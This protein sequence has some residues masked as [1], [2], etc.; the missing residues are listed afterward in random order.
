MGCAK[1]LWKQGEYMN[2][3]RKKTRN[4]WNRT[5]QWRKIS[6]LW[7]VKWKGYEQSRWLQRGE[8]GDLALDHME[9]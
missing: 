5:K 9:C 8:Q 1:S 7:L 2:L 6:S 3:R 4:S